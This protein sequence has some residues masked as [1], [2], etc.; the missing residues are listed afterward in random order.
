MIR[1]GAASGPRHIV[2]Q[3]STQ[4]LLFHSSGSCVCSLIC[5]AVCSA[6]HLVHPATRAVPLRTLRRPGEGPEWQAR[7]RQRVLDSV[8][9]C[10]GHITVHTGS[11]K[12][13]LDQAK[14]LPSQP[15]LKVQVRP[16]CCLEPAD[17]ARVLVAAAGHAPPAS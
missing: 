17:A 5:L 3:V 7:L 12:H 4:P 15:R 6:S 9:S 8:A 16:P 10:R 14:C 2:H 1:K 11:W 13:D